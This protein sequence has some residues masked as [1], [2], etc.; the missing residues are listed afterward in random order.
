VSRS[1]PEQQELYREALRSALRAGYSVLQ[2]GGEAI[3]AAVAAVSAME[4]G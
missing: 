2:A 3:D 1:T 4:G